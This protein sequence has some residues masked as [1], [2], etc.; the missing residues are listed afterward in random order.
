M[1][2]FPTGAAVGGDGGAVDP[3][4][5]GTVE[6]VDMYVESLIAVDAMEWVDL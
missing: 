2:V 4:T 6:W 3:P 1:G 5:Q